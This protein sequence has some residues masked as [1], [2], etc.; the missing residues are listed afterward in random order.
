MKMNE[1]YDDED[2]YGDDDY[3][4]DYSNDKYGAYDPY[5]FYFKFDI[6][7]DTP[8]SK[9]IN[10]IVNDI[11]DPFGLMNIPGFPIK[12]FPVNSWTP[13]TG[14]DN[15]YQYLGSNYHGKSIWKKKYFVIDK[16][17]T[18]YRLHIQSHAAHFVNQ[19]HY[20]KGLMDILN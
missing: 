11:V 17:D 16:I 6:S 20:Y 4:Y 10:D 14:K 3:N 7:Q 18:E 12:K 2:D 13:N 8:L 5:K 15:T 9:W 1:P 19:P